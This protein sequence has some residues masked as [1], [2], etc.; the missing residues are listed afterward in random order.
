MTDSANDPKYEH[1]SAPV[2]GRSP[3]V[4]LEQTESD[5]LREADMLAEGG[6]VLTPAVPTS[7]EPAEPTSTAANEPATK[8]SSNLPRLPSSL[9]SWQRYVESRFRNY[10]RERLDALE[11]RGEPEARLRTLSAQAER[12]RRQVELAHELLE[13]FRAGRYTKISWRSIALLSSVIGYV[14]DSTPGVSR[15]LTQHLDD[16]MLMQLVTLALRNDLKRYCLHK[17]YSPAEY[18]ST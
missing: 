12:A 1:D 3:K 11:K 14:V 5:Q 9:G 18:F 8:S 6:G 13:D 10:A 7:V 2:S 4:H 17:R 16:A 15:R